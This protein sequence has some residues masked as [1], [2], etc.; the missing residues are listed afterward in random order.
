[1]NELVVEFMCG[2]PMSYVTQRV[3]NYAEQDQDQVEEQKL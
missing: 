2:D 1:M 3:S